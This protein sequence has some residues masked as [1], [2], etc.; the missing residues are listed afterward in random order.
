[1]ANFIIIKNGECTWSGRRRF[2]QTG[3][4]NEEK[5][6]DRWATYASLH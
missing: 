6:Y 3:V 5:Q 1:M 2:F 4:I